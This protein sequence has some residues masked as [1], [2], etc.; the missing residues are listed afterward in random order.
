VIEAQRVDFIAVPTQ[1]VERSA[2]FYGQV[3]GLE[4]N[5]SDGSLP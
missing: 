2:R 5:R 4:K 3:L 1:D